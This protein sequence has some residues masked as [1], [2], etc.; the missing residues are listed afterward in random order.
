MSLRKNRKKTNQRNAVEREKRQWLKPGWFKRGSIFVVGA[1]VVVWGLVVLSDPQTMPLKNIQVESEFRHVDADQIREI[2]ANYVEQGFLKID[3][4]TV[5]NDLMAMPWVAAVDI[6]RVWPD[7]L[8]VKVVE[9]KAIARWEDGGL[10]DESGVLFSPEES[11]FPEDIVIFS[12]DMNHALEMTQYYQ[13]AKETISRL[14]LSIV[15]ITLDE[16][17]A[18]HITLNNSMTLILGRTK[19]EQRLQ[20]FVR[21]YPQLE[22]G[23]VKQADLRYSNGF[24]IEWLEQTEEATKA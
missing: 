17:H 20:R 10:L 5:K 3:T 4:D 16:R 18:W 8:Y 13:N 2:V 12:G 1:S 11:T 24:S 9:Y 21:W 19:S 7:E 15:K 14:G 23:E 6:E 22:G